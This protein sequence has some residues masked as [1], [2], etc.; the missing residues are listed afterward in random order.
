MTTTMTM[1]ATLTATGRP[2]AFRRDIGE[3]L[4]NSLGL[5]AAVVLAAPFA[6]ILSSPFLGV[7]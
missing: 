5:L 2:S 3:W 7:W 4:L 6:L 1:T